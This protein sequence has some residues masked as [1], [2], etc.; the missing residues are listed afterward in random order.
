MSLYLPP[1]A[2]R[3]VRFTARADIGPV[4]GVVAWLWRY[5]R[6]PPQPPDGPGIERDVQY[7][8]VILGAVATALAWRSP[9]LGGALLAITG[10]VL[11]VLA[12]MRYSTETA[13]IVALMLVVPGTLVPAAVEFGTGAGRP[14]WRRPSFVAIILLIGAREARTRHEDGIRAGA[15]GVSTAGTGGRQGRLGVGGGRGR[16]RIRGAGQGPPRQ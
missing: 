2:A 14:D 12:A 15:P 13:L 16:G 4:G 1:F 7:L 8:F 10:A 5:S 6:G 11:G 9:G 3:A